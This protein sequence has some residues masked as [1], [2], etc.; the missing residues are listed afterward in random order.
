MLRRSTKRPDRKTL[1]GMTK[2]QHYAFAAVIANAFIEGRNKLRIRVHRSY[3]WPKGWPLGYV[4]G[5]E[6]DY[7]WLLIDTRKALVWM[8][9][10][11]YN[12]LSFEE[13]KEVRHLA[14]SVYRDIERRIG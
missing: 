14:L 4:V 7:K 3:I 2:A 12:D 1:P 5:R 13:L 10:M 11:G 6:G 8:C 9:N